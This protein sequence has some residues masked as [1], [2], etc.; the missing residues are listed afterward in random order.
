MTGFRP[1]RG[2]P[3]APPVPPEASGW[4][5]RDRGRRPYCSKIGVVVRNR[6]RPHTDYSRT[7]SSEEPLQNLGVRMHDSG[8]ELRVWSQNATAME[9]CLFRSEERRVGKE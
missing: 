4:S 2:R 5:P 1:G 3:P 7:M 8:G 9:L 6:A